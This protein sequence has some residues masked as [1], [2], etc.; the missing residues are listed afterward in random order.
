MC[1]QFKPNEIT[2]LVSLAG[3][4]RETVSMIMHLHV[5]FLI[6][7]SHKYFL[8]SLESPSVQ[9]FL[10]VCLHSPQNSEC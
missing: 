5:L 6:H 9:T 8:A 2:F 1:S 10:A 7:K 4:N 3:Y